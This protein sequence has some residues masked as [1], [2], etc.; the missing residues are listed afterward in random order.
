M[1]EGVGVV[2]VKAGE[3]GMGE[4]VGLVNEDGC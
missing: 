3:L 2:V 4:V 1:G